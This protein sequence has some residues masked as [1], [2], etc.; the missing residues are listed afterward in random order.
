MRRGLSIA[1]GLAMA[2]TTFLAGCEERKA[3]APSSA[4]RAAPRVPVKVEFASKED[5]AVTTSAIGWVEAY[6]TV[7]VKPQVSGQ[8]Q[9]IHFV[10]GQELRAGDPLFTIDPRPFEAALRLAESERERDAAMAN[11]AER[12]AEQLKSLFERGQASDRER[13]DARFLA[14]SRMAQ[15]RADDAEIARAK[16]EREYCEIRSPIDGRTGSF[17]VDRGNIVKA[18]E[19][20]MVAINQLAPIF[21]TFS[22]PQQHLAQLRASSSEGK[23]DVIAYPDD[24]VEAP[25][26]GELAFIDNQVD[27][28]TGM[29]RLK[30]AFENKDHRL[31]PGSFVRVTL[32]TQTLR[33]TVVVPTSAVQVGQSSSYVYVVNAGD[34]VEMKAVSVGPTIAGR[35]VITNGLSGDEEVV[36]DGHLRLTPGAEIVR[37]SPQTTKPSEEAATAAQ[38]ADAPEATKTDGADQPQ[39]SELTSQPAA[40]ANGNGV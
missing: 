28:D 35:T 1:T 33:N 5:F 29:L 31:W 12:E 10:E 15:V 22:L 17:L 16:L 14:D 23:V 27:R 18:D 2:A 39:T 21:V 4:G 9:E 3:A 38:P 13:D 40:S 25:A 34:A 6:A 7:V 30:A 20:E 11:N 8:L 26:I 37:K 32:T 36:T 19:T 24:G